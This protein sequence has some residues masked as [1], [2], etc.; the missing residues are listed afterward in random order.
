MRFPGNGRSARGFSL[1][2]MVVVIV[3]V[4]IVFAIGATLLGRVFTSFFAT[5]DITDAE[6]Q[7][8][9]ALERLSRELREVRSPSELTISPSNRIMFTN[10]DGDRVEYYVSGT[11][12]MRSTG[13]TEMTLADDIAGLNFFYLNSD[14]TTTATSAATVSYITVRLQVTKNLSAVGENYSETLRIT[15]NTRY[16]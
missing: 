8:L 4:G 6:W 13:N 16:D 15:V 12:L 3:L 10:L 11:A 14:G 2:E 5:R 7:G 1:A 9:V